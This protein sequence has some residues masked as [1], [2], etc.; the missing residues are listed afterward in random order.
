MAAPN[1]PTEHAHPIDEIHRLLDRIDYDVKKEL[2][3]IKTREI[4]ASQLPT[5]DDIEPWYD[6][7]CSLWDDE[8]LYRAMSA[9][10]SCKRSAHSEGRQKE[11]SKQPCWSPCSIPHTRGTVFR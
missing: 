8:A 1:P 11:S 10:A 6:A 7:V 5:T 9:R 4:D 3:E 2:S